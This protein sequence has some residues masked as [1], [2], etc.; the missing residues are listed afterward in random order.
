LV[1]SG[2]CSEFIENP[3]QGAWVLWENYKEPS[4]CF[5]PNHGGVL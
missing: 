1:G 4:L 2:T 3:G 5:I